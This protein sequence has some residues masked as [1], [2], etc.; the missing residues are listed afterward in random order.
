MAFTAAQF[1]PHVGTPFSVQLPDNQEV[2]LRLESMT[3]SATEDSGYD[4]FSL[5]FTDASAVP[6]QQG[7]YTLQHAQL[8]A[9]FIFL[10]PIARAANGHRYQACFSV[11][12]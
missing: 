5:F 4:S 2:V 7:A 8:P 11:E 12:T 9:Q 1:Q 3:D 10:V 6:L